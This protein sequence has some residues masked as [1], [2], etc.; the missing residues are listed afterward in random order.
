HQVK[1]RPRDDLE[2][3]PQQPREEQRPEQPREPVTDH[4]LRKIECVEN[5][6]TEIDD[7]DDR[8]NLRRDENNQRPAD[9]RAVVVH[10]LSLST[11]ERP[12]LWAPVSHARAG[13]AGN[14]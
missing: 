13:S 12:G 9:P 2:T 6:L 14:R 7:D 1:S 11:T 5:S 4:G 8:E 3:E 10:P